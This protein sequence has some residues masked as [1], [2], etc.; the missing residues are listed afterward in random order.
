MALSIR[1]EFPKSS[2]LKTSLHQTTETGIRIYQSIDTKTCCGSVIEKPNY[3]VISDDLDRENCQNV[4]DIR[5][6]SY[7]EPE[8]FPQSVK[9]SLEVRIAAT[10]MG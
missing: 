9:P 1:S 7:I 4:Y 8:S 5:G 6:G 10:D 3:C 2:K